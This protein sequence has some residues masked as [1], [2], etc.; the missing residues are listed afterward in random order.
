MY[1]CFIYSGNKQEF[2]AKVNC[3]SNINSLSNWYHKNFFKIEPK[4]LPKKRKKEVQNG[5]NLL[6]MIRLPASKPSH[7]STGPISYAEPKGFYSV[8]LL[9]QFMFISLV[10]I[11]NR[12]TD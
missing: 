7:N 11:T 6:G 9:A 4:K 10:S 1:F 12:R 2:N 5:V 3:I 8:T